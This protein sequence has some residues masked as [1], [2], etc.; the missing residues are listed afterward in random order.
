MRGGGGRG[1][2]GTR[3]CVQL[4]VHVLKTLYISISMLYSG[5]GCGKDDFLFPD[6]LRGKLV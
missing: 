4:C 2:L 3:S 6:R 1:W 5:L